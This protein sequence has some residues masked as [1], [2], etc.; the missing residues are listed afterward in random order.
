MTVFGSARSPASEPTYQACV[1]FGREM[2]E[3]DWMVITGAAHGIMEAGH[4][5]AG[6]E[7]SMGLNI[8]LPFEQSANAVIDG[9]VGAMVLNQRA[10]FLAACHGKYGRAHRLGAFDRG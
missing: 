3:R 4:V 10:F 2:A 8:M 5:G 9:D 7:M 1:D 6:R